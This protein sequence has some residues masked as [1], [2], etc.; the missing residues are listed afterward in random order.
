[1]LSSVDSQLFLLVIFGLLGF[2]FWLY[3]N[4]KQDNK[5]ALQICSFSMFLAVILILWRV[6]QLN[7]DFGLVLTIG[8][9][10]AGL[11]W[12]LG[13]FMAFSSLNEV[14]DN[15]PGSEEV[16][17]EMRKNS[18]ILYRTKDL[19]E[20]EK[21]AQIDKYVLKRFNSLK[22]ESRS[23]FWILL[24]IT[25]IRSFAYEPYQIPSS[26]MYP[27]L[28]VGDFVLV[29]KYAYGLRLPGTTRLISRSKEPSR[30]DVAVFYPPHTLCE[31]K[32]EDARPDLASLPAMEVRVFL[33]RFK[34][35]QKEYCSGLGLK[36]IKRVVGI[37]GDK[38]EIK[39]YEIFINDK[40]L[41]QIVI[42]KTSEETFYSEKN[43]DIEYVIRTTGISEYQNYTWVI[44]KDRYLAI[45][46]N[47]DNSLDSKDWGYF[48]KEN[49]IGKGEYIWLHWESFTSLPTFQRNKKI[50]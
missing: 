8:T 27:G 1:M 50:Q 39:G 34:L 25:C 24:V 43:D 14:L 3:F 20:L 15:I 5:L 6:F 30:G 49:L 35:L 37:P 17:K 29:N 31:S 12:I 28:Q 16:I 36:Y 22:E 13:V 4:R 42:E 40:K 46:D 2:A 18:S 19:E 44:P 23:Y 41:N 10:F 45:G 11:A 48:S 47:R 9:L 7:L 26:S 33:G 21:E 32:P 38:V